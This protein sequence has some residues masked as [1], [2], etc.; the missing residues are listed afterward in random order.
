MKKHKH[1]WYDK[2]VVKGTNVTKSVVC[3]A[4]GHREWELEQERSRGS[5]S[6]GQHEEKLLGR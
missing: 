6:Q 1:E 2:I 4:P 5:G 3:K